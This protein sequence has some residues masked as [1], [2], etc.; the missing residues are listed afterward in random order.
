MSTFST[1]TA[2]CIVLSMRFFKHIR[3]SQ[4]LFFLLIATPAFS[5]TIARVDVVAPSTLV[6]VG[7]TI[8]A[9]AAAKD[10]DGNV[11]SGPSFTWTSGTP[12]VASV[13]SS[14]QVTALFPGS[15][16]IRARTGNIT[17]SL[18]LTVIPMKVQVSGP[19]SVQLNSSATLAPAAL[20][21]NGAPIP[22]VTFTWASD[23][24]GVGT[25]SSGTFQGVNLGEVN[26]SATS[27]NVVGRLKIRVTR[28]VDYTME[29]VVSTDPVPG[30]SSIQSIIS[31]SNMNA[32]GDTA[33]VANLSGSTTVLVR[34]SQG[35]LTMLARTGDPAPLGGTFS[36]FGQPVINGR[37]DVAV[38]AGVGGGGIGPLLLLFR[39]A[40][41]IPLL[42]VGDPLILGG[43]IGSITLANEGLDDNGFAVVTLVMNNPSY[44]GVF[45]ISPETNV[46]PLI[47]TTDTTSIGAPT[48]FN[49]VAASTGGRVAVIVTAGARR[50]IFIVTSTDI[51]PVVVDGGANPGGGTF[52][53]FQSVRLTDLAL[54][55]LATPQGR[56]MSLYRAATALE[57]IVRGG[58]TTNPTRT[59]TL[60]SMLAVGGGNLVLSATLSDVGTGVYLW[61]DGNIRPLAVNRAAMPGGETITR[62]D[63]ASINPSGAAAFLAVTNRNVSALYRSEADSTSLRWA[64]ASRVDFPVN[65]MVVSNSGLRP[66]PFGSYFQ[67]GTPAGLHKKAGGTVTPVAMPGMITPRG[68]AFT[69]TSAAASNANGD[70][71]FVATSMDLTNA[72][73]LTILYRYFDNQLGE[74]IPFNQSVGGLNIGTGGLTNIALNSNRQ[75]AFVGTVSNRQSLILA[76][77][78]TQVILQAGATSPAGGTLTGFSNIQ[79]TPA[80]SVVFTAAVT[81]GPTGIFMW[82]GSQVTR[83]AATDVYRNI[84]APVVGGESIYFT[85][86]QNTVTGLFAYTNGTVQPVVTVGSRLPINTTI[87]SIG[88]YAAQEDGTLVFQATGSFTGVFVRRIDGTLSTVALISETSPASGRFTS[89][90]SL[91]IGG[92]LVLTNSF[93]TQDRAALFTGAPSGFRPPTTSS[94]NFSVVDRAAVSK[95]TENAGSQLTTGYA[96]IQPG[97]G[98][99]NPSG[100]AIFSYRQNGVLVSEASVPAM[101]LFQS[102]RIYAEVNGLTDTG[103]AFANPNTQAAT[104]TFN[105]TDASGVDF[106]NA[107]FDIPAG[108]QLAR[109]L[110]QA[111]FNGGASMSGTLTFSSSLPVSVISL[112]GW[113]NERSEFLI[114]TLP[115]GPVGETSTASLIFPHYADGGGWATQVV[116]V[117]STDDTATGAVEFIG[118]VT[119]RTGYSIPPRTSTVVRTEGTAP[120]VQSGWV[121]VT[122]DGGTRTPSG[123][124][125]FS[126]R[127][128]GVTVA[129]AGVPASPL[130]TA[131]RL[132]A[133]SAGNMTAAQ[134]GSM[135][136]GI[137][138]VNPSSAPVQVTFELANLSGASTGLIGRTTIPAQGHA[139][140]FTNQI[141]G[142]EAS[143]G[144]GVL[145]ITAPTAISVLG[146]RGRY[147]ERGD[148]LMS[149]IPPS[150]EAEPAATTPLYM[151]HFVDGGG[152]TTQFILFSGSSNQSSNGTLRFFSQTGQPLELNLR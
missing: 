95:R 120:T 35:Q 70:A 13:D 29:T 53:S 93:V 63:A 133:E 25:I 68:H 142:L 91:A 149:T 3:I 48:A 124:L 106:G 108:G 111:P 27:A 55:F 57:E 77:S 50:G 49:N 17:G 89:F 45:R 26:I 52:A 20:D 81:G 98:S 126:L 71:A 94:V 152:Y 8:A 19:D 18:T 125:I 47:Q 56:P 39:G 121:R 92:S 130:S 101:P 129:Q 115:I 14:G 140:L 64:S 127:Q 128:N 116:L 90:A 33:F 122:P 15:V 69:G 42:A 40:E 12:G 110:D 30:G 65:F 46:Q 44:S 62:L 82:S 100:L 88:A 80:G 143:P 9:V 61:S 151:P 118:S 58:S 75:V 123:L 59:T 11:I 97:A 67:A 83:I 21:I 103:V 16:Q 85:A 96:S 7:Q 51:T 134:V 38:V 78:D 148:F 1:R 145:R 147:N 138:I 66:S 36:S 73:S 4:F 31:L 28:P 84:G 112:R 102:G 23:N 24:T 34:E 32:S 141:P 104:I 76:G 60:N 144:Q 117:N 79:L 139:G 5:Q 41:R 87:T 131:F 74:W 72:S 119:Q 107:S 146:L 37:G 114:T 109:F 132:F 54:Y 99:S 86:S 22:N 6:I 135:Q 137:A 10:A 150:N 136:T 43:T 113:A 2:D 105:F